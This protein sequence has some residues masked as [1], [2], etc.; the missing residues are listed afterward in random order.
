MRITGV[1]Q[2]HAENAL[3]GSYR[4]TWIPG[5]PQATNEAEVIEVETDNG[6]VGYAA[7]PSFAGGIGYEE[8][9]SLFLVGKDPHE[10]GSVRRGLETFDLLGPRP[11]HVEMALWDI[12]GKDAG[13]P[14]YELLG[15]TNREIRAYASTGEHKGV[16]ERLAYVE[17]R[18]SEGFEAVKLRLGRDDIEDDLRVAHRVSDEFPDLTLMADANMGW[19]ARV[20]D[21][22]RTWTFS[23]ALRVAREL[24]ALGFEWLEEPLG[25][26]DYAGY[27]RLRE[28]TD[29]AIAGGEF[30]DGVHELREMLRNDALDIVQPDCSVA[31]GL[32]Q[33]KSIADE[34]ERAGVRYTPHSWTNGLGLVANLHIASATDA[35]WFEYP[36]EPPFDPGARDFLLDEP[37]LHDD[38]RVS[39]PDEPGLGVDID[40]GDD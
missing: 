37:L 1:T 23:E 19:K 30:T 20:V 31:C 7:S 6:T 26:H 3:D 32:G 36:Y 13:K 39:P 34:A 33:A 11:W 10:L 27:A 35:R 29:I 15:G 14:V 22:G 12:I 8:Q 28:K 24:D 18:V 4:P 17:E 5:Y 21:E 40:L 2:H 25:R 38:G 16:D 9:L